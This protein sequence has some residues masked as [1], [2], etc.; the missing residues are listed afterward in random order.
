MYVWY[1]WLLG[2]LAVA[3]ILGQREAQVILFLWVAWPILK[4]LFLALPKVIENLRKRKEEKEDIEAIEAEIVDV[5]W[6]DNSR[7]KPLPR[8][9]RPELP[10]PDVVEVEWKELPAPAPGW[11]MVFATAIAI[12]GGLPFLIGFVGFLAT[13]L[14]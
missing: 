3:A 6:E 13:L 5:E 8:S 2:A 14:R 7:R 11:R 10:D 9:T 4:G 1:G 12:L